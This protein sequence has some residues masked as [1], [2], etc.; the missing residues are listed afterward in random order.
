MLVRR[1]SIIP[2][3]ISFIL[4]TGFNHLYSQKTEIRGFV[5]VMA[6]IQNDKL[7]FSL[8]EQDLFITSE[9][10][11]R[12]TFLGE[13]VFKFTSTTPTKFSVSIER[14]VVKYNLIGNHN[15]L[16]GKH[17]TPV[18]YWNDMYHHGRVFF[19]TIFR[20]LIF[21]EI[22]PIHTTGISFQGQNLGD[23]KFGYDLMVGNGI[24]ST[25]ASD[26]D[27]RKSITT[28]VHIKPADGLRFGLSLYNDHISKGSM[29]HSGLLNWDVNQTL[30][31]GSDA[32]FGNK[33]E[34]LA[35]GILGINKS[36]TTGSQNTTASYLY[37]GYK[38]TEKVTPY[39]R[40]DQV[41]FQKGEILFHNDNTT[42]FVG[43]IRF[44]V[45][46][47]TALKLEYQHLSADLNGKTN[48]ITAQVA[49]GF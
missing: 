5:D 8:G 42:S 13:S 48:K 16:I 26:N 31:T 47:L 38:L 9:L 4:L 43:G 46:Y 28:A 20:P 32:Y 1:K 2:L 45:N 23:V 3:F 18:N 44:N 33:F 17:H 30:F 21:D 27:K 41:H 25:D 36:D 34:V 35:E 14:I 11:D 6:G 29:T 22:V 12:F 7:S 39:I 49:I 19:P 40:L 37:A 24:G 15:I 10:S